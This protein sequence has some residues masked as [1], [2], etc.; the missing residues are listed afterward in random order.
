[1]PA[2]P[3][4]ERQPPTLTS[5]RQV[6][7]TARKSLGVR[8]PRGLHTGG[9]FNPWEEPAERSCEPLPTP[10]DSAE[11]IVVGRL[12]REAGPGWGQGGGTETR[13]HARNRSRPHG[14]PG[15]TLPGWSGGTSFVC[16][17]RWCKCGCSCGNEA[18]VTGN[19]RK[20]ILVKQ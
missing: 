11:T 19:W 3:E 7:A 4:K 15:A 16:S 18:H 13:A 17:G 2:T 9:W 10:H 5:R 8:T 1:M 20:A 14:G 12:P 6:S